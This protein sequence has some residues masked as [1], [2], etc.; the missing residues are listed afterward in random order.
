MINDFDGK[1]IDPSKLNKEHQ[2]ALYEFMKTEKGWNFIAQFA[3][4]G[5]SITVNGVKF[6]FKE[7]GAKSSQSAY[8]SCDALRL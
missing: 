4:K 3:T 8:R 2:Q 5:E 1:D 7:A 6:T